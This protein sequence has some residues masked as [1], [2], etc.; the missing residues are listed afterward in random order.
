[1][2]IHVERQACAT[3]MT[4]CKVQNIWLLEFWVKKLIV[5]CALNK[6]EFVGQMNVQ[7]GEQ[8]VL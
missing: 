4:A 1:M 3:K 6:F 5:M 7:Q 2:K 8:Q